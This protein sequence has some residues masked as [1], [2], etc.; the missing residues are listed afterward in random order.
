MKRGMK[1]LLFL[2][3]SFIISG[4]FIQC[5]GDHA[6]QSAS[7][8]SSTT[9][10]SSATLVSIAVTPANPSIILATGTTQTE[11]FTATG[12]YS[13][14]TT[15]N[16]TTSVSWTSS[17]TAVANF[18][19]TVSSGDRI[20]GNATVLAFGTTT[21]SATFGTIT[22]STALTVISTASLQSIQVTPTTPTILL[23]AAQQFIAQ[24]TNFDGTTQNL[25]AS[26]T[27][28]SSSMAV[29]TISN[30]PGSNGK[31]TS[32]AA[33]E[34]TITATLGSLA[35]S[36]ILTITSPI[37]NPL[38]YTTPPVGVLPAS[39]A[40]DSSGDAWVTNFGINSVSELN[41]SGA[42]SNGTYEF[43]SLIGASP[44]GIAID[45]L[46]NIWTAN[47]D[48]N[49]ITV[50]ILAPAPYDATLCPSGWQGSGSEFI[51]FGSAAGIGTG[52]HGIAIDAQ[53]NAWVSNYGSPTAPGNTIT[54]L[55]PNYSFC[56]T[57]LNPYSVKAAAASSFTVGSNPFGIAI[58]GQ[59]NAWVSNYGSNNV[60]EL[61]PAGVLLNT[62]PVG[63]GP[64]GIAIDPF[65]NVWV[66]NAG[67]DAAPGNTVTMINPA[68]GVTATYSVSPPA[69]PLYG[70]HSI[71]IETSGNVWVTNFGTTT[72][73]GN[74]ITELNSNGV[75]LH[76]Y[77]VGNNPEGIA[78][79]FSG[80]VWVT[81]YYANTLTEWKGATIGP[82]F[83]PYSGPIWPE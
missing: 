27:W 33:G 71:A 82:H 18:P 50:I 77:T 17:D 6:P 1:I 34:T 16:L 76:T 35:G 80:N 25:T 7:H 59:G 63:N 57:G 13:D 73:P 65:G 4:A 67:S 68:T 61:S 43:P 54:K 60:T 74:T 3:L 8:S 51:S 31:A 10:S 62:F 79:D 15:Q 29:A 41:P 32:V 45:Y 38:S 42:A 30:I 47:Y 70:P 5:G 48:T 14:G 24:G 44:F 55:T 75:F 49:N 22:G 36:T 2:S 83:S 19:V 81:N 46:G 26:V 58:D 66:A 78:I 52:P 69:S 20:P 37:Q 72:A 23:G 9:T 11:Q 39:I 21:I 28:G 40:F 12:T 56:S 53:G 64:R